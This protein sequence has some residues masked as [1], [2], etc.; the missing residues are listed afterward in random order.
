MNKKLKLVA[1]VI[2]SVMAGMVY[3]TPF[4]RFTF[5]DQMIEALQITDVQIGTLGAIYGIFALIG[6]LPGGFLAEKFSAKN[7]LIIS[8]IGMFAAT[9]WYALY[10]GFT[11]LCIIHGMYG[12]FSIVTFWSAYLKAVRNLGTEE[13]Q[14]RLYGSSEAIRGIGQAVISF[15]CLAVVN[16]FT[17]AAVGFRL[18][19]VINAIVFLLL[20]VAILLF[21]PGSSKGTDESKDTDEY[22]RSKDV[23]AKK[24][25]L[26]VTAV[27]LVKSPSIWICIFV[28]ISGFTVWTTVNGYMGTYGTRVLHLSGGLSS[29]LSIIRSYVVVI[30]AGLVGGVIIDKFSCKGKGLMVAFLAEIIAVIGI[31]L[32]SN[33]VFVCIAVT[34][35]LGFFVNVVKS[36]YW[37]ILGEAGIPREKTGLA[38][39]II[40]I[41]GFTPD[42]FSA[43]IVSRFIQYGEQ[44]RNVELGFNIMLAW[45]AVWGVLGAIA[46]FIL[47]RHT[48]SIG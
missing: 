37:S 11:A 4:L 39:G 23:V 36:T 10:P 7:L 44:Q 47:K 17:Q 13:E 15:G 28:I 6:Y 33:L 45:V 31:F 27:D 38:T 35:L 41:V 46:A 1:L 29:T 43:P 42:V 14:A 40:S 5:Y 32:T 25:N 19:L 21:I 20:T 48:K 12:T 2:L 26:L 3:L 30:F 9:A 18:A 22:E 34:L 16:G 8:A 24:E